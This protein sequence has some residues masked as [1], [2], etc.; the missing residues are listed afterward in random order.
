MDF[1]SFLGYPVILQKISN[2]NNAI[3]LAHRL[4]KNC[5][6]PIAQLLRI[7]GDRQAGGNLCHAIGD[8][9]HPPRANN[10]RCFYRHKSV[11]QWKYLTHK[12]IYIGKH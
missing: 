3:N 11:R 8:L 4:S 10:D 5:L 12:L 6:R 7:E 2:N 9:G 1:N